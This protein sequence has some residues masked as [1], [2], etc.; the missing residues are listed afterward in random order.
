MECMG[1]WLTRGLDESDNF[2]FKTELLLVVRACFGRTRTWQSYRLHFEIEQADIR[3]GIFKI[4]GEPAQIV[5][6]GGSANRK[7]SRFVGKTWDQER[8]AHLLARKVGDLDFVFVRDTKLVQ[9]DNQPGVEV[10]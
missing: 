8:L 9:G 2:H 4:G 10:A 5:V 3:K 7:R 6:I 1:G